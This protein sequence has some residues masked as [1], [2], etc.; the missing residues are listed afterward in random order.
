M[1]KI[2]VEICLIS[3][4][5]LQRTSSLFKLQWYAVGWID[6][7]SK[8]CTRIDA[9]G[10]TNPTWKTKFSSLVDESKTDF[11][12]LELNVEVYSREPIFLRERLQGTATIILKEFLDKFVKISEEYRVVEEVGSFQLRKRNSNKPQ[13]FVDVSIRVSEEKDDNNIFAGDNGEIKLMDYNNGINLSANQYGSTQSTQLQRPQNRPLLTYPNSSQGGPSHM[14]PGGPAYLPP[15]P[16]P[17]PPSYNVGYIPTFLP[18]SNNY[19]NS[20]SSYV[21][22]PPG[23]AGRGGGQVLVWG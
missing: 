20:Q 23:G 4:R 12:N 9:C 7:K 18:S 17:P 22:M 3:A 5:G 13:G 21:S 10:N 19:H 16:P 15:R 8:Y 6:S 14:P 1:G 11:E 2:C